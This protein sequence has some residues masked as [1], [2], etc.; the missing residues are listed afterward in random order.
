[1][2]LIE[3]FFPVGCDT[4]TLYSQVQEPG[5]VLPVWLWHR[6]QQHKPQKPKKEVRVS[7]VF[8][9]PPVPTGQGR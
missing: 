1:M 5:S 4:H 8:L 2:F 3:V 6:E 9:L 7:P